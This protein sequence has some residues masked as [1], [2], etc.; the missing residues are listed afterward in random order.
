MGWGALLSAR[1]ATFSEG[2]SALAVLQRECRNAGIA[3]DSSGG[4]VRG[5]GGLYEFDGGQ[6][7]GWMF[8]VNGRYPNYGAS[9][10]T[11]NNGDSIQ[12][13]YTRDMGNDIGGG[14]AAG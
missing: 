13:R 9:S 7:S 4:Y 8:A 3:L 2:E 11:V 14:S 6:K 1:T 12:W 5:I 10:Y